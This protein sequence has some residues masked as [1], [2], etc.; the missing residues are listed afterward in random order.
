MNRTLILACF[1]INMENLLSFD[2]YYNEE[3][4]IY[5]FW[6]KFKKN[7][8]GC[9]HCGS[10]SIW[11]KGF[12]DVTLN[13]SV[14]RGVTCI[15]HIKTRRYVCNDCKKTFKEK[16]S[17]YEDYSTISNPVKLSI[18]RDLKE[19][20]TYSD[21]AKMYDV[22][23]NF[24][25]DTFDTIPRISRTILPTVMCIDEFH[26]SN[27]VNRNPRY[28]VVISNPYNND[29][30]DI[31]EYR[32]KI[33]LSNYFEKIPLY[34]RKM[35]KYFVSDMNQTFKQIKRIYFTN[36]IHIIDHFHIIKGF[37]DAIQNERRELLRKY[38]HD[39]KNKN[40]VF[41]KNNRN[42]FL[43]RLYK[44]RKMIKIGAKGYSYDLIF[45]LEEAFRNYREIGEIYYACEEFADTMVKMMS[46][47]ETE[48]YYD[49]FISKISNSLSKSLQNLAKTLIRWKK[50]IISGY[51]KNDT[52]FYLSNAVA[53][54]NNNVIQTYINISYGLTNFE[55][56]RN[57][58][59]YINMH[60][61]RG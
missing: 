53:E 42:I 49:Y 17:F 56:F 22:S 8:A 10:V 52:G 60:R 59:L 24:V 40:Y 2:E 27:D 50:E 20:F 25:I 51:A 36:A 5:H 35:V 61:K 44:L 18:L 13:A 14:I 28:P 34:E 41:L 43:M 4:K 9:P 38:K 39:K 26:F 37:N 58:I 57:R 19:K 33:V 55:R 29:I 1:N 45:T 47:E 30:V 31:I 16:S 7:T 48:E 3:D 46:Y 6:L 23:V 32:T 11:S 12:Y 15:A 21:I 54:A